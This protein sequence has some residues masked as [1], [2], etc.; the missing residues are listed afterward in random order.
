MLTKAKKDYD[1]A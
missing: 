1:D